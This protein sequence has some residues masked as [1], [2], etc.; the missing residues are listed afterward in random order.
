[1]VAPVQSISSS[2][3][4]TDVRR[5][6]I[7]LHDA[8]PPFEEDIR[9]QLRA[10]DELNI[11]PFVF[12]VVPNWHRAH[13]L[14]RGQSMVELLLERVASGS[15]IVLHGYSHQ[16]SGAWLG[17][18]LRRTRARLFAPDA[19]EFMT[20]T[21]TGAREA[22]DRGLEELNRAGLPVPDTFCAP[23]WL[24]T[25]EA[26][27]AIAEV[28]LRYS[29]R[30]SSVLNVR[31]GSVRWLSSFGYMGA[32]PFHEWGTAAMN[33]LADT[34]LSRSRVARAYLHPDRSGRR[35]WKSTVERVDRMIQSGWQ[36]STF[37]DLSDR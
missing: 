35:G 24:L 5:L 9:A 21:G 27:A 37:A 19:A 29:V 34:A 4:R 18:P 10:L 3:L 23:A 25:G 8:A 12:K 36:P 13:P 15:Q 22:L 26:E 6:V 1:M 14:N 20:L 31:D 30:M 7:S 33:A 16:P 2:R 28:G 11:A 32:G 17:S